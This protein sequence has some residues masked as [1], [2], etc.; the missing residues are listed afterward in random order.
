MCISES[1]PSSVH[2]YV[3]KREEVLV[4]GKRVS[5]YVLYEKKLGIFE[6]ATLMGD[7]VAVR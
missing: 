2:T 7:V 3:I 4:S 1:S 6:G 5:S